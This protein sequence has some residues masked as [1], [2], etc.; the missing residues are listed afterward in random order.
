M[1]STSPPPSLTRRPGF[2]IVELLVVIAILIVLAALIFVG[3]GSATRA[4]NRTKCANNLRQ[5]GIGLG[6]FITDNNRFPSDPRYPGDDDLLFDR[7]I[8]LQLE[9][10]YAEEIASNRPLTTRS[11]SGLK[12]SVAELFICPVDNLERNKR[13]FKRSYAYVPWANNLSQFDGDIPRGWAHLEPNRG[14]S[15]TMVDSPSTAAIIV[16]WHAGKDTIENCL[17]HGNHNVHDRGGEATNRDEKDQCHSG[18]Q[19]V[20]FVDGHVETVNIMGQKEFVT[21]YWPKDTR[22]NPSIPD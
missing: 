8:L 7:E 21:K 16:E 15:L 20:L 1:T 4:A 2:T 17:G 9:A 22:F 5:L 18:K 12:S 10:P 13:N 19:N 6:G 14:V 3:I 11:M